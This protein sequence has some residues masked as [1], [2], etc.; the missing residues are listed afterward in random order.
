MRAAGIHRDLAH[1]FAPAIEDQVS[2]AISR[3][4]LATIDRI[5]AERDMLRRFLDSCAD[6]ELQNGTWLERHGTKWNVYRNTVAIAVG[7]D[8][9]TAIRIAM[10]G[11]E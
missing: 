2:A 7:A 8:L 4:D 10:G 6:V 1:S 11:A 5:T 9:E 3:E